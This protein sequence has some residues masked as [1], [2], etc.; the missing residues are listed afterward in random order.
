MYKFIN[1]KEKS[2]LYKFERNFNNEL[3]KIFLKAEKL[4]FPKQSVAYTNL[5][6]EKN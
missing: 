5:Y 4:K 1:K 2:L 3:N 6:Y